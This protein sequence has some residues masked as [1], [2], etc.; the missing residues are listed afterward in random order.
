MCSLAIGDF[1]GVDGLF[2]AVS[3]AD[4]LVLEQ[5]QGLTPLSFAVVLGAGLL[6]SL[7][8]CTLSVLPLT[9]GYIGGYGS[10]GAV[11]GQAPALGRS[12]LARASAFSLGL[13]TT[14]AALG[15]ASSL[16]GGAYGQVRT[17]SALFR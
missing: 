5:L 10:D 3:Q 16:L 9:I 6:T 15:V 8:P 1:A 4:Q 11:D 13:A 17:H 2:D 7:S 14:L 12:L